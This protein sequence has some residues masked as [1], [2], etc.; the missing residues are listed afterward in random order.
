MSQAVVEREGFLAGADGFQLFTRTWIPESDPRAVLLL[1]HGLG[2]H[3]G[4][5]SYLAEMLVGYGYALYGLD[6]R[7]HGRSQGQRGFIRTWEDY[8]SDLRSFQ[9][10]VDCQAANC[11]RFLVGH[12]LGA[13][14]VLDYVMRMQP[15]LAGA[16]ALAPALGEVGVPP[17]KL[18][19]GQLLSTIWPRFTLDTGIDPFKG[20]RD[21]QLLEEF[22]NDPLRHTKGTARLATEFF[23]TVDW[24]QSHPE[25]LQVPLLILHGESDVV[26]LP[27]S[28]AQ[29]VA[30]LQHPDTSRLAYPQCFHDIHR[31]LACDSVVDDLVNWLNVHSEDDCCQLGLPAVQELLA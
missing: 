12:S 13:V 15:S 2:S 8:R 11:T 23:D 26:A 9:E 30:Q 25:N 7:G 17:V 3:S 6:L 14:V 24:I 4:S 29:F 31:D 22:L 10:W 28:S 20:A 5:F 27:E 1:V 18:A 21:P 19:V 16:I